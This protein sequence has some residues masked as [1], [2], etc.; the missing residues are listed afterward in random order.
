MGKKD[1]FLNG[2]WERIQEKEEDTKLYQAFEEKE[3]ERFGLLG[4]SGKFQI[5]ELMFGMWDVVCVSFLAA[6]LFVFMISWFFGVSGD[7]IYAAAFVSAPYLYGLTFILGW[8]KERQCL[9][10]PLEMC[11]KY[12]FFH[13]LAARMLFCSFLGMSFN[14]VYLIVLA[15]RFDVDYV[16]ML[17]LS[18]S[19]LMIFSLLLAAGL[20]RGKRFLW[21]VLLGGLWVI[22]NLAGMCWQSEGYARLLQQIPIWALG[23]CAV[24][25]ASAYGY[26][27]CRLTSPSFR[28]GYLNA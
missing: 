27:L 15:F 26:I 4:L 14:I 22:V 3:Q 10:Y 17:A 8:Q 18:F 21:A 1:D 20:S 23:V 9:A 2:I 28:K 7:Y 5:S 13:V 6:V 25:A 19:A 24:L 12:T 16:R 11:C